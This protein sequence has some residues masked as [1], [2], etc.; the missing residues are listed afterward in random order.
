LEQLSPLI[1]AHQ[2]DGSMN[3]AVL[4]RD[5]P[6][7]TFVLGGY[8]L[9]VVLR[10]QRKADWVAE[11]GYVLAIA[12]QADRFIVAGK[13]V[14]VTF[15]ASGVSPAVAEL[16]QVEEGDFREGRWV[17]GRR[18]NGDEIMLDYDLSIL[19]AKNQ[20][21]TGL[22]FGAGGPTVVRAAVFRREPGR[23]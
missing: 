11:N 8:T 22:S 2:D 10:R 7:Q 16:G 4:N 23:P 9:N 13:D 1:L 17:P 18:L 6:A 5:N 20:T 21:G 15:V 12:E 14:E 19:A 3:A